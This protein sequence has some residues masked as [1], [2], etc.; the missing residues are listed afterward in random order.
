MSSWSTQVV[1]TDTGYGYSEQAAKIPRI[2]VD[3]PNAMLRFWLMIFGQVRILAV[4][5][6][7]GAL[8]IATG[9]WTRIHATESG[10]PMMYLTVKDYEAGISY[11]DVQYHSPIGMVVNHCSYADKLEPTI[12]WNDG[13][14][15]HKPDTNFVTRTLKNAEPIPVI[16]SGVYLFWDDSHTA[17][18]P[19]TTAVTTKLVVHCL[20]DPPGDKVY[21]TKNMIH[22]YARIP[23]KRVRYENKGL[24]VDSVRGHDSV[25]VKITLEAASPESGTWVKLTTTPQGALNSLPPFYFI[26]PGET[27]ATIQDLETRRPSANTNLVTT[28][29][30]SGKPQQSQTLVVT[31]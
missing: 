4:A 19:G 30:T 27:S 18:A 1:Q 13:N 22:S 16:V 11:R 9:S 28:A 26:V 31:P 25:D 29:S 24:D 21:E 3:G 7:A 17:P 8:V 2:C 15:F 12:D 20:G 5:V 14:G 6:A 10:A 23:V